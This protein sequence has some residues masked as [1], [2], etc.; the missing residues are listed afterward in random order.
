MTHE[1]FNQPPPLVDYDLAYTDPVLV[2]AMAREGAAWAIPQ[3]E[4]YGRRMASEEVISWGFEANENAPRLRT[5]DRFGN[6][7][8]RVDFHPSWHHLLEMAVSGGLVSLPWEREPGEGGFPARTALTFLAGQIEQGHW[9]PI[10][11]AFAVVPSLR[12][13]PD[14]AAE[15]EPLQ[16]SR[17]Y[18]PAFAPAPDK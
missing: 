16:L 18:D 4:A 13:Q 17:Q 14:V 9:C 2:D 11:M 5:H 1:V 7:V 6:R 3:V 12:R 8:D 15:W 10:S